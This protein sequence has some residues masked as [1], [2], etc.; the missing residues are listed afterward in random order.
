MKLIIQIPC[1]NEEA[2]LPKTLS[3]L[4]REVPGFESVEW[5]IVD[6]GSVDRTVAVAE[7]CGVNHIVKLPRN[8]GLAKAFSAGISECLKQGADVIVNTDAD[9][10]YNAQDIP[11]LTQPILSGKAEFVIGERPISSI[12]HFSYLKKFLQNL[13]SKT[14]RSISNTDVVDAPSGFR[15]I[16]RDAAMKLNVFSKYTYTLE[17]IIQAGQEGMAILS[18]PVRVNGETRPSRLVK[19]LSSYVKGSIVTMLR[20]F[21]VYRPMRFFGFLAALVFISGFLLGVR[22]LVYYLAGEGEGHIQSVILSALLMG[23]GLLLAIVA[24]IADLISVNRRLLQ[25]IQWRIS[26]LEDLISDRKS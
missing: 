5:L 23:S 18:V 10:Q 2:S 14:V 4:P 19:S 11:V 1:F 7:E 24:L 6:D 12:S 9:N 8:R 21:V 16:S 15:A 13:G 3:D 22:F 20:I 25:Q 17:T 26:K